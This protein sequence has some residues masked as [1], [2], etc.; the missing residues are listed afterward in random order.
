[1]LPFIVIYAAVAALFFAAAFW[2]MRDGPDREPLSKALVWAV[3]IGVFW[4]IALA[5]GIYELCNTRW[6]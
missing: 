1:M 5:I 3:A 4:P 6:I 2:R